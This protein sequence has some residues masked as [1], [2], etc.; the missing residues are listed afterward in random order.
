MSRKTELLENIKIIVLNSDTN[1]FMG[2]VD[3]ESWMEFLDAYI[4]NNEERTENYY[5]IDKN[6]KKFYPYDNLWLSKEI[7]PKLKKDGQCS[8]QYI[9]PNIRVKFIDATKTWI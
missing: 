8:S 6:G 3:I 4:G 5:S 2:I 7:I 1:T 9:Y